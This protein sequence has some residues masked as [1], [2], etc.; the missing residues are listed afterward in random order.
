[1]RREVR[2]PVRRGRGRSPRRSQWW[3]DARGARRAGASCPRPGRTLR[4]QSTCDRQRR[5][6][7][8]GVLLSPQGPEVEVGLERG[9]LYLLARTSELVL[10]APAHAHVARK[11]DFLVTRGELVLASQRC[12]LLSPASRRRAK[13]SSLAKLFVRL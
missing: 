6:D 4:A 3:L 7:E 5:V 9:L 2:V 10:V 1:M 12:L 11:A 8:A 13:S